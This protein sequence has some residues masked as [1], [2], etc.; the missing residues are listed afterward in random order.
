MPKTT[1]VAVC[2]SR[3]DA[4]TQARPA[5]TKLGRGPAPGGQGEPGAPQHEG[6]HGGI[7]RRRH[8]RAGPLHAEDVGA[9]LVVVGTRGHT[10]LAGLMLGSVTDRLLHILRCP[11]LAVPS[12]EPGKAS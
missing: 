8:E 12:A 10:P 6:G 4:K 3:K 5:E 11:V 1:V 7:W 9:D 2:V